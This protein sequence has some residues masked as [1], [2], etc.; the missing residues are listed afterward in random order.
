MNVFVLL[1]TM[2]DILKKVCDLGCF[3]APLTSIVRKKNTMEVNGAPE[4]VPHFG[5][6]YTFMA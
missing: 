4:M 1:N 6:N 3:G 2:E 5:V